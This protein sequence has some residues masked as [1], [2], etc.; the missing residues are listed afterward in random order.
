[1]NR[2]W[3]GT[4]LVSATIAFALTA[5]GSK[6]NEEAAAPAANALDQI[7]IGYQNGVSTLT[8]LKEQGKLD[9]KLK[10]QG[11][12]VTWNQ[13]TATPDMINAINDGN[14]LDFGGGGGTG[15]VFGQSAGKK[16]VRVAAQHGATEGS[17]ILVLDESSIQTVAD[18]KGKKVAVT[19][20][21]FQQYLLVSAL[22]QA[23]LTYDDITPLY[24]QPSEALTAFKKGEV[25]AWVIWDPITAQAES[26]AKT[27]TLANNGSV[28]GE[29]APLEGAPYYFANED[30]VKNHPDVLKIIVDELKETAVWESNHR[31]EAAQILADVYKADLPSLQVAEQRAG[32]KEIIPLTDDLLTIYQKQADAFFDLKII[33]NK[34]DMKD[35]SYNWL[36]FGE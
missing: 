8:L 12:T 31:D 22:K 13:F 6:N 25:D 11:I 27:R 33:P 24:L 34:I 15:P 36:N 28:F 32:D 17:S 30:L 5:C 18:L 9:A 23:G 29:T 21:A 7:A 4:I 35:A 16:F 3:L 2:K 14:G 26:Q 19:K 1:M 20:G 10:E